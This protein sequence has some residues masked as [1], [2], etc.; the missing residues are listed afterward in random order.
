MASNSG[1]D[2]DHYFTNQ[3]YVSLIYENDIRYH[4]LT[5]SQISTSEIAPEAISEH[6]KVRNFLGGMPPDPPIEV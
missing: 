1:I 5:A 4:R 2:W 6:E 3:D